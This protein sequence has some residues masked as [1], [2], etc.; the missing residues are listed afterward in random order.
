MMPR[1]VEPAENAKARERRLHRRKQLLFP[2]IK[3]GE[4]NA[5]IIL[6]I[7]ENGLAMQAVKSLA[8]VELLSIRFQLSE[9]QSWVETRGRIAW[10]NASK[11]TAGVEFVGL[12]GEARNKIRQWTPL[13]LHPRGPAEGPLLDDPIGSLNN[14]RPTRQPEG[15]SVLSKPE[16]PARFDARRMRHTTTVLL[17]LSALFLVGSWFQRAET[18]QGTKVRAAAKAGDYS[19]STNTLHATISPKTPSSEP[20]FVL[21][22]A[23]MTHEE[24]AQSLVESLL[25]RNLT[26]FVSRRESDRFYR[27]LVGPFSDADSTL[28]AKEQ[29]KQLGFDSFRT[30]LSN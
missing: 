14:V 21:Q 1:T 20:R 28:R 26:A 9:S 15:T 11:H 3:L 16:R 25:K 8:D 18:N 13:T 10:V 29:L 30:Q 24:S 4:D 7:S 12:P 27:V 22:V 2:W 5:G 17:L 19:P 6:D 23:A